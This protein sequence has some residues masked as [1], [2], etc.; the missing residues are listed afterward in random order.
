MGQAGFSDSH[1][2]VK[3]KGF[4]KKAA[5]ASQAAMGNVRRRS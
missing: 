2:G 1:S 4:W 5:L 3:L